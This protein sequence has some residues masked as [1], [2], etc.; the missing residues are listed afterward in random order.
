M[1]LTYRKQLLQSFHDWGCTIISQNQSQQDFQTFLHSY[2]LDN[3]S[4]SKQEA[5]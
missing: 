1:I 2:G 3:V 5:L 4:S